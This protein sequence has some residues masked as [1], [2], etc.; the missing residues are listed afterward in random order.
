M[1]RARVERSAGSVAAG[2]VQWRIGRLLRVEDTEIA[3]S[4]C[5]RVGGEKLK[6][7]LVV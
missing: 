2:S 7:L 4:F 5:A 3:I 1:S 6:F